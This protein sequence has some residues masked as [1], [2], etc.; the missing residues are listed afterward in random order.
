LYRGSARR[1]STVFKQGVWVQ[2]VFDHINFHQYCSLN[3]AVP[4][5]AKMPKSQII[6]S[7]L[8]TDRGNPRPAWI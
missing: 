2:D 5:I 1:V 6:P 4:F 3:G 8:A 7:V